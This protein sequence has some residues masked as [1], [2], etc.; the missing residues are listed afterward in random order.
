MAHRPVGTEVI[1]LTLTEDWR[2][3]LLTDP[4]RVAL[5]SLR[6][7]KAFLWSDDPDGSVFVTIE[8]KRTLRIVIPEMQAEIGHARMLNGNGTLEVLAFQIDG[9][10]S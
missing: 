3:I 6:E 7:N 5:F 10:I 1:N 2:P 4:F 9:S 8:A